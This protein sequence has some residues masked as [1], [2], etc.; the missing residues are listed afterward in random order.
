MKKKALLIFI[1]CIALSACG[2]ENSDKRTDISKESIQKENPISKPVEKSSDAKVEKESFGEQE[3]ESKLSDEDFINNLKM[4][5]QDRWDMLR[6]SDDSTPEKT[7]DNFKNIYIP[8]EKNRLGA[9]DDYK[10]NDNF[11]RYLADSYFEALDITANAV[12]KMYIGED[13][14]ATKDFNR[15]TEQRA[16]IVYTL[17][18][19]YGLEF[20]EGYEED[21]NILLDTLFEEEGESYI[22]KDDERAYNEEADNTDEGVANK[23]NNPLIEFLDCFEADDFGKENYELK[24]RAIDC[25]AKYYSDN[26]EGN[27]HTD[28]VAVV[29]PK[30]LSGYGAE[31][32]ESDYPYISLVFEKNPEKVFTLLRAEYKVKSNSGKEISVGHGNGEITFFVN[33]EHFDS[34]YKAYD[35]L[36]TS[37]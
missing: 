9:I 33:E 18:D 12:E 28:V 22:E 6:T 31:L 2:S 24:G 23:S 20:D 5:L 14:K 3:F 36:M 17:I 32:Y 1:L 25:G 16:N 15:Y 7:V 27:F 37:D 34:A 11:I 8:A 35:Y 21:V 26:R 30:E 13:E 19:K 29:P 4:G 10:F